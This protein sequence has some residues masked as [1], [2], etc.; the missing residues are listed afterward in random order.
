MSTKNLLTL[1][2]GTN[3][4]SWNVCSKL[5]LTLCSIPRCGR[6]YV[7]LFRPC[8]NCHHFCLSL[9]ISTLI[10]HIH[11]TDQMCLAL[12]SYWFLCFFLSNWCTLSVIDTQVIEEETYSSKLQTALQAVFRKIWARRRNGGISCL[13]SRNVASDCYGGH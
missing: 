4:L 8:A 10:C 2:N 11:G 7:S 13:F 3:M 9:I 5:Q 6:L 12:W 1:E